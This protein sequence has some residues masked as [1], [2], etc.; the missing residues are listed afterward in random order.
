MTIINVGGQ[1]VLGKD[2]K[3]MSPIKALHFVTVLYLLQNYIN[4]SEFKT[5]LLSE[6]RFFM[7]EKTL[8]IVTEIETYFD[9]ATTNIPGG[10]ILYRARIVD[11]KLRAEFISKI[12]E[13]VFDTNPSLDMFL[14]IDADREILINLI[15]SLIDKE[16]EKKLENFQFYDDKSFLGYDKKNSGAPPVGMSSEGRL[17]PKGISYLYTSEDIETCV[18]EVKPYIG[19][20][21]S[22][23][24]L[25]TKKEVKIFDLTKNFQQQTLDENNSEQLDFDSLMTVIAKEFKKPN[26]GDLREY[27][28]TQYLT[29]YIKMN[30]DFVGVKFWSSMNKK[31]T[32]IIFF[33]RE[34]CDIISS[35][36]VAIEGIK[37][38]FK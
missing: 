34:L 17:N 15:F 31:G 3:D 6:S 9:M 25:K 19:Q 27:I 24:T 29:E 26:H 33:D 18:N 8:N 35:R 16:G 37:F 14:D 21:V 5:G 38:D 32:N 30:T 10:H 12:C 22:I 7:S 23:A 13:C 20:S 4:Y 36:I 1:G 11:D 2:D 28:P